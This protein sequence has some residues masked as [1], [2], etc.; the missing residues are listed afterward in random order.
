MAAG[1]GRWALSRRRFGDAEAAEL[2]FDAARTTGD[3]L[4]AAGERN[5]A[6]A[7]ELLI[8]ERTVDRTLMTI[9]TNAA[10]TNATRPAAR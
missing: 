2:E 9:P 3:Q 7:R 10:S 6:I 8:S 4:V 1:R 5:R